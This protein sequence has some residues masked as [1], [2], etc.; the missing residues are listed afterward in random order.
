MEIHT[1]DWVVTIRS[2]DVGEEYALDVAPRHG[3][4]ARWQRGMQ[5]KASIC[6]DGSN[7]PGRFRN[8]K[9]ASAACQTTPQQTNPDFH[10]DSKQPWWPCSEGMKL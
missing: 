1:S 3:V 9:I 5:E 8:T 2:L 4:T 7:I 10:K 6:T